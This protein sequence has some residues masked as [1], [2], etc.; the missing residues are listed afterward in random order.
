[1]AIACDGRV[2]DALAA[3]LHG[4]GAEQQATL[5]VAQASDAPQA[6]EIANAFAPE[7]LQLIGDDVQALASHVRSAGCVFVGPAAG[8]AFGDYVAGSN[9]V[10]PTDGAA[11]FASML[12]SRHF[13][14]TMGE[15]HIDQAAAAKLAR[16]G[17]PIA[18]AEGFEWHARSMQARIGDNYEP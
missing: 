3:E 4:N 1:M 12:S 11:R 13:R 10:L 15:V 17:V 18:R 16:A 8:T 14:R 2:A 5:V 9:H 7:H 6:V